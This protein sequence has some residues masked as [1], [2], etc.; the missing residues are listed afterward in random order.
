MFRVK[1]IVAIVLLLVVI[2][3]GAP[4]VFAEGPS[5]TPGVTGP[6]ETPGH[7]GP[8]ETPGYNGPSET[9]GLVNDIILFL[10]TLIP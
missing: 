10:S 8:S 3:M 1:R 6:S 2:G 4:Q 5:E 7:T 9:P